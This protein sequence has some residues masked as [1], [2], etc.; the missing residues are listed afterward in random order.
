MSAGRSTEDRA[1]TIT[2]A[3]GIAASVAGGAALIVWAAL[4]GDAWKIV[5]VS[6]FVTTLL[7]LYSASTAYHAVR[8]P[9]LKAR[10]KVLDHGAIYLLIA[11]TYTPFMIGDL[12]G[13]WGWSLFGVIWALALTGIVFKVFYAGRFRALSTALYVAMGW[14]VLIAVGPLIHGLPRSAL[15]WLLAGGIAYTAGTP[16]Y[17]SRR[18]RFSHAIWHGFV[19]LGSLCHAIAVGAGV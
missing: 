5:G 9:G 4:R 8:A 2:H 19:L 3:S 6:V 10:L 15:V 1:N 13:G 16:F 7:L 11:G 14:L 18:L 12:R 17:H